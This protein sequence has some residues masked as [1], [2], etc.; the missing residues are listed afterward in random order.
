[1][2]NIYLNPLFYLR[3]PHLSIFS[4]LT[5]QS[6]NSINKRRNQ[7]SGWKKLKLSLKR[8]KGGRGQAESAD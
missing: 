3:L 1:M 7:L 4:S 8:K 5:L 6:K 2:I